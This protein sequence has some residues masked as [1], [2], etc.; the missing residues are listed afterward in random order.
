[1]TELTYTPATLERI[2]AERRERVSRL[3]SEGRAYTVTPDHV[4]PGAFLVRSATLPGVVQ[5]VTADG[6]CSCRRYAVWGRCKHAA[7]VEARSGAD[8]DFPPAV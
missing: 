7:V 4:L 6:R 2:E 5:I 3:A 8:V 1:M